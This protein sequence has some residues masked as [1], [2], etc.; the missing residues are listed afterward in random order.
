M[1]VTHWLSSIAHRINGPRRRKNHCLPP[2][3]ETLESKLLLT[4]FF[5][6][7]GLAF[8]Q[9]DPADPAT[10]LDRQL[11]SNV[12]AVRNA[13][14]PN[15][16][17]AF[18]SDAFNGN[19]PITFEPIQYDYN[20]DM[21]V[22]IADLDA[23][24][25]QVALHA[26]HILEPFDVDVVVIGS[27]G[28][29]GGIASSTG[30]SI[31]NGDVDSDGDFDFDD[32]QSAV[33]LNLGDQD[34]QFDVYTIVSGAQ[35]NGVDVSTGLSP[36]DQ[37]LGIQG[38]LDQ[39][40]AQN[41]T[42]E[43]AITFANDLVADINAE[44]ANGTLSRAEA[45]EQLAYALAKISTHEAAHTFGLR[46]TVQEVS[47]GQLILPAFGDAVSG[48]MT[49]APVRET[50]YE[51]FTR[52]D[53]FN[54]VGNLVNNY[55][56]I[57]NDPDI[58]PRDDLGMVDNDGNEVGNG[59]PDL[60]Y[61]TGTGLHDH[62]II[63]PDADTAGL[64]QVEV[65]VYREPRGNNGQFSPAALVDVDTYEIQHGLQFMNTGGAI[66]VSG[67]DG[68]VRIDAGAGDDLIDLESVD[69]T[70]DEFSFEIDAGSGADRVLGS[71]VNDIIFGGAGDDFIRGRSGKDQLIGEDGDDEL[72]GD[73]GTDTLDGGDGTDIL[74]GCTETDTYVRYEDA[75]M[76]AVWDATTVGIFVD[77]NGNGQRDSGDE[78]D[79]FRNERERVEAGDPLV[80]EL[81]GGESDN[82]LSSLDFAVK[83]HTTFAGQFPSALET[84]IKVRMFGGE[85][86]DALIGGQ[87]RDSLSGGDGNDWMNGNSGA[88]TL[89]GGLGSDGLHGRSGIDL[90]I[91]EGDTNWEI[92]NGTAGRAAFIA[93]TVNNEIDSIFDTNSDFNLMLIGGEDANLLDASQYTDGNADTLLHK[94]FLIGGAGN[95]TLIGTNL[96]DEILGQGGDDSII[97]NGGDD[98][99]RS[100]EGDDFIDAG[101]GND[102]IHGNISNDTIFAGAGDDTVNGWLGDDLIDGGAGNDLLTG[103]NGNDS[104]NGGIGDDTLFGGQ[105]DDTVDGGDGFD[106]VSG[107]LGTDVVLDS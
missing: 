22:T 106:L 59:V 95:D 97:A 91:G 64:L 13:I 44:I 56:Q 52:F 101:S 49:S 7:L 39:F 3:S 43:L 90:Y 104:I 48:S 11:N 12:T 24:A 25:Q 78:F 74:E 14:G 89:S 51:Y 34:G 77:T 68:R 28:S 85:G 60:A 61:V 84:A 71:H 30:V 36:G 50:E 57:A 18:E 94:V 96:A 40:A 53:L 67:T 6:D 23:L 66:E 105:G 10:T 100:H 88:D 15:T 1:K 103:H 62:I 32:I 79:I 35:S 4:T 87:M 33:D 46:H 58:G 63:T 93:D 86:N 92:R 5:L 26:Q 37:I 16:G 75:D 31:L 98:I 9:T 27:A 102:S 70:N 42:D 69:D 73:G 107:G 65:R 19:S 99:I 82:R 54:D 81:Y 47:N 55:E 17:P 8:D 29:T 20:G 45:N 38:G 21:D 41:S 76:W 2:H 83:T 72:L 80:V